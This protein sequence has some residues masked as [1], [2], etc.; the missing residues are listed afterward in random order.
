MFSQFLRRVFGGDRG[1]QFDC[2]LEAVEIRCAIGAF[3]QM[4]LEFTALGGGEL[5]VKLFADVSQHI[6]AMYGLLHAVM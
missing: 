2:R 1:V 4:P 3:R 6:G 5:G